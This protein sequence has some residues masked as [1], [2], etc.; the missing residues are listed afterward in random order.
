LISV[1]PPTADKL[2]HFKGIGF[3]IFGS[4]LRLIAYLVFAFFCVSVQAD[5][6]KR[7]F[8]KPLAIEVT[9]KA[10]QSLLKVVLGD[11]ASDEEVT[12]V[13]QVVNK[14]PG[15]LRFDKNELGWKCTKANPERAEIL[16][17]MAIDIEVSAKIPRDTVNP[18]EYL[19][20]QFASDTGQA[21]V[22]YV[23]YE[24]AFD[25]N[26]GTPMVEVPVSPSASLKDVTFEIPIVAGSKVNFAQTDVV[27]SPDQYNDKGKNRIKAET[28]FLDR[29]IARC[30]VDLSDT[31]LNSGEKELYTQAFIGQSDQGALNFAWII[32]KRVGVV[33]FLP[34]LARF[35]QTDKNG[36]FS[37]SMLI[38]KPTESDGEVSRVMVEIDGRPVQASVGTF[39]NGVAKLTLMLPN[40]VAVSL[41]K[42]R[43][44]E[45]RSNKN[46]RKLD[47]RITYSFASESE[48]L[49]VPTMFVESESQK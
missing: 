30:T 46:S 25:I 27:L 42:K 47:A 40:T 11:V 26:F 4:C 39:Q 9:G 36:D 38:R 49:F 35:V 15:T 17:G 2:I 43:L 48:Q 24:L 20:F 5:D 14:T 23:E 6:R 8:E 18:K 22:V 32:F 33:R 1:L 3:M 16:S 31:E 37:A 12:F 13:L 21:R 45:P 28:V 29:K 7:K 41:Q 44:S 10:D 19:L 34:N